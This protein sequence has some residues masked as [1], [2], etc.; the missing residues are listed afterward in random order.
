[1]RSLV[2]DRFYVISSAVLLALF[3]V[4]FLARQKSISPLQRL[5]GFQ[6]LFLVA[7]SVLFLAAI[8]LPF[9]FHD[10]QYPSRLYPYFVSGRIISSALLPFVLL[11]A[12]GLERLTSTFRK[13]VSPVAVL[14]CIMLFITISEIR[15]RSVVFSSPYNFFALSG[16]R[17]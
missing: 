12:I 4:G 11:Y 17:Y 14:A 5:I 3:T 8:S 1:M 16:W 10:C 15:M 9:D 7:S 2:A 6:A 13:W